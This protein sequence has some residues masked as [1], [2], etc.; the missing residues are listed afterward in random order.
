MANIVFENTKFE[1]SQSERK[2]FESKKCCCFEL[3]DRGVPPSSKNSE[4]KIRLFWNLANY[5]AKIKL[6]IIFR[7]FYSYLKCDEI[8]ANKCPN[9]K[10]KNHSILPWI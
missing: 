9:V 3:S 6:L 10:K 5:N 1:I 4:I 2:S 7:E 8:S